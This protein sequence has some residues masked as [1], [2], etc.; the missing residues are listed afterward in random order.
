MAAPARGEP[1]A[2]ALQEANR[3]ALLR[4]LVSPELVAEHAAR[5][6]GHHSPALAQLL[7]VFRQAP[8]AG[9]L[10][11]YAPEP[12]AR[13]QIIRLSGSQGVPH[14]MSDSAR[15]SSLEDALH[16]VFLR[17][18]VDYGLATRAELEAGNG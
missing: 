12:G 3:R 9:K 11:L 17:R 8:V 1:A 5:P 7:A 15:F 13:W 4:A 14:D 16:E 18:L 6:V 10:A 2:T